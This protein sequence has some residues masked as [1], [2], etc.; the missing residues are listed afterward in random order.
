MKTCVLMDEKPAD[1]SETS[2]NTVH[3]FSTDGQ[4]RAT[5]DCILR[6]NVD[7]PSAMENGHTTAVTKATS[8]VKPR[9]GYT[10]ESHAPQSLATL[11]SAA[12]KSTALCETKRYGYLLT[13]S[14][15]CKWRK[16]NIRKRKAT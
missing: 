12:R 1:K 16:E 15:V 5:V 7:N 2:L 13:S 10:G 14:A 4:T 11:P 9:N 3:Q 8:Y 6:D